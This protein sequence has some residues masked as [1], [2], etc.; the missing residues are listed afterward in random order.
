M[1]PRLIVL[2][3]L[4]IAPPGPLCAF[5]S[6]HELAA[7][8]REQSRPGT[9]VVFAGDIFD[10][11]H[12][13][14]HPG[15]LD[16]PGAPDF[17]RQTLRAIRDT[18]WGNDVFQAITALVQAGGRCILMPGNH[19][20]E[21]HHPDARS[22]LLQ[23]L[24]LNDH[25]D[26]VLYRDDAPI[27]FQI[28]KHRVIVG[29]G[30][31]IDKWNDIDPAAVRRAIETGRRDV[32]LPPG[33]RLVREVLLPFKRA[34][35]AQTGQPRFPFVDLLKPELPAV[36]LLLLYFDPLMCLN[37]LGNAFGVLQARLL[38]RFARHLRP[39]PVLGDGTELEPPANLD[40]LLADSLAQEMTERERRAP[41]ATRDKLETFLDGFAAPHAGM[42]ATHSN[43]LAPVRAALRSI[44]HN[45]TFFDTQVL[46]S[47]D[48]DIVAKYLMPLKDP[49]IGI[50]GHTHA[51]RRVECG[52]HLYINTGTWMGLMD[53]PKVDDDETLRIW[54]DKLEAGVVPRIERLTYAEVTEHGA[55]LHGT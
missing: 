17:L 16:M 52:N 41:S 19:D 42:L 35:N 51:A 23:A 22:I 9:T 47:D 39:G 5:Q 31:R 29:H 20:P 4:H 18:Q 49:C 44:S 2:S 24:E 32:E 37:L 27:P 28:G 50:F 21:L 40:E 46:S 6:G 10:L 15:V 48:K 3:D 36:P 7:L 43:W 55:M 12:V 1:N 25:P 13:D 38:R 11:L 34:L 26:F 30:H 8:L 14:Q 53:L 54:L 33:S 45:N